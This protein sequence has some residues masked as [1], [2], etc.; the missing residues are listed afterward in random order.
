MDDDDDD[1]FE[2]VV[3]GGGAAWEV[4]SMPLKQANE[5]LKAGESTEWAEGNTFIKL[6]EY[7]ELTQASR[8]PKVKDLAI[9]WNVAIAGCATVADTAVI[10]RRLMVMMQRGCPDAYRKQAWELLSGCRLATEAGKPSIYKEWRILQPSQDRDTARV[11]KNPP[12]FGGTLE[13]AKHPLTEEGEIARGRMLAAIGMTRPDISFAPQLPHIVS[14]AL[15]Y[16]SETE[17]CAFVETLLPP[18][19]F[20]ARQSKEGEEQQQNVLH[21]VATICSPSMLQLAITAW[22]MKLR[23]CSPKLHAKLKEGGD[24]AVDFGEIV[25][26]W[27]SSLFQGFAPYQVTLRCLDAV[28][29]DSVKGVVQLCVA[30]FW[31]FKDAIL[32]C[33]SPEGVRHAVE[34]RLAALTEPA[35]LFRAAADIAARARVPVGALQEQGQAASAPASGS[36]RDL[37]HLVYYLPHIVPKSELLSEQDV[38]SIWGW[39]PERLAIRDATVVFCSK[40]DGC[41]LQTVYT[42]AA[43][44]WGSDAFGECIIVIRT[45]S[46]A[47]LGAFVTDWPRISGA[48]S[49]GTGESFV[50][51]LKPDEKKH[52]WRPGQKEVFM[53]CRPDCLSVGGTAITLD[54]YMEKCSSLGSETFDTKGP[55]VQ[56]KQGKATSTFD[57]QAVEILKL[58]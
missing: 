30:V 20:Q 15:L 42:K 43:Q 48:S 22:D 47:L 12:L 6:E 3:G 1:D 14:L 46:G 34:W 9:R 40:R 37:G 41:S 52:V 53:M 27:I 55:L 28:V 17:V 21:D 44:H 8:S 26:R 57:V 2:L 35:L 11:I 24:S 16:M 19:S 5:L 45:M 32:A 31:Y 51:S 58:D 56:A 13:G 10:K 4:D 25:G 49:L 23:V 38:E 54:R 29:S 50:F 7:L 33:T 18:I 39:M 36:R